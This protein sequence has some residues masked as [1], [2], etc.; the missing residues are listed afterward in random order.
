MKQEKQ[1]KEKIEELKEILFRTQ[2][3]MVKGWEVLSGPIDV[4]VGQTP[5]DVV[6]QE[7]K[8]KVLHYH[9]MRDEV[10]GV[11][12][13]IVYALVNRYYMLDLQ[14]DRSMVRNLLN[15][16][17]DL[18]LLDWGYPSKAD[19]YL[20]LDD[21]INHYLDEAVD[22]IRK[23]NKLQK[24]N[25][26][27]I[28]QGG[29]FSTIYASL[30]PEKIKNLITVVSPFNFDSRDGLLNLWSRY[31]DVN[32]LVDTYGNV[33]GDFLNLGFLLLNPIR[34]MFHKYFEFMENIDDQ[35]FVTNFVR[36]EKWIFDSPDQAGEAFREFITKFYQQNLLIK[37]KLEIGGHK[38]SLKNVIMPVLNVFAEFDNLVPPV[39]S[40]PLTDL[41]SSTDKKMISFPTGHIGIFVGS[42]S[43]KQVCP[44]IAE[45]I[46]AR[47]ECEEIKEEV[48]PKKT[49]TVAK[50]KKRTG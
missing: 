44:Q 28:C 49:K 32:K 46:L 16:G 20:T 21:Y 43:Q 47:S 50:K 41:V 26:M 11:P 17:L 25:I 30:H 37:D 5:H 38:V 45:W 19:R 27:G 36:M 6:L 40:K 10:C 4:K 34:L 31:M 2:E 12:T 48:M 29:T 9:P 18:Y 8:A 42:K 1:S 13:L 7:D 24:I 14:E 23:K 33:P 22:F 3:R 15:L 39:C 35:N